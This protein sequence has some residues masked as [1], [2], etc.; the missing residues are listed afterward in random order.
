MVPIQSTGTGSFGFQIMGG[1]ETDMPATIEFIVPGVWGGVH[2]CLHPHT[3][4]VMMGLFVNAQMDTCT[5]LDTDNLP[6]SADM[7]HRLSADSRAAIRWCPRGNPRI[8]S[9]AIRGSSTR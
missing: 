6:F 3:F 2:N 9:A 7:P 1:F 8:A 5:V 4:I